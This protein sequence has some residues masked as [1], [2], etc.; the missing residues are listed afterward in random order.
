MTM[1]RLAQLRIRPIDGDFG[2]NHLKR[3]HQFIFQDVYPFAGKVRQQDISKGNTPF[4]RFQFISE[5]FDN[6]YRQL[7]SEN[8]LRSKSP[9]EFAGRA[10]YFMGEINI[11]HPFREGNGRAQREYI[12][13]LAQQAG[14]NL[15]WDAV[16][17]EQAFEAAVQSVFDYV[18]LQKVILRCIT[19][20]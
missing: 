18:P 5:Q 2:L 6:M 4:A 13:C 8:F 9:E 12:R 11:I 15:D 3:I 7:K 19:V 10:A 1:E 16:D 14:I 20:S 17:R